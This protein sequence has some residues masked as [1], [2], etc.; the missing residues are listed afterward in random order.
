ML[1]CIT[2]FLVFSIVAVP[3]RRS[4]PLQGSFE[5]PVHS[6][7]VTLHQD[8]WFHSTALRSGH[9]RWSFTMFVPYVEY[10]PSPFVLADIDQAVPAGEHL[11]E[12]KPHTLHQPASRL[13]SRQD[14]TWDLGTPPG[15]DTTSSPDTVATLDVPTPATTPV[16]GSSPVD[17]DEPIDIIDPLTG[18]TSSTD[19]SDISSEI[20]STWGGK[21]QATVH[22]N[23]WNLWDDMKSWWSPSWAAKRSAS[24]SAA[25]SDVWG[26][27]SES[28]NTKIKGDD[29]WRDRLT[30]WW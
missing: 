10:V 19:P 26:P 28:A 29:L 6:F 30:W 4:L 17:L 14:G 5:A 24:P 13:A 7:L 9:S 1:R 23:R 18:L 27:P 25:E 8:A 15:N 11:H 3:D 12:S 22:G 16:V 20:A 21:H 2:R